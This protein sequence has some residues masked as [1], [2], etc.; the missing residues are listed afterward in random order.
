[1]C[2]VERGGRGVYSSVQNPN[3]E[4][5]IVLFRKTPPIMIL[6]QLCITVKETIKLIKYSNKLTNNK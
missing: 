5:G 3:F 2:G 6:L 1:M 4:R